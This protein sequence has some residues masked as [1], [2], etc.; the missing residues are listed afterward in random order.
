MTCH[1]KP[2]LWLKTQNCEK[3]KK[4]DKIK[5]VTCF[6]VFSRII[7]YFSPVGL[8]SYGEPQWVFLESEDPGIENGPSPIV[9]FS[10]STKSKC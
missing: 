7:S 4:T 3:E 5:F 8:L 10:Y 6:F 9:Y 2:G 1:E